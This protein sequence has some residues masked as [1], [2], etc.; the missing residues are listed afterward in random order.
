LEGP[1]Q[2]EFKLPDWITN[3]FKDIFAPAEE[4]EEEEPKEAPAEQIERKPKD[5]LVRS[6]SRGNKSGERL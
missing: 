5:V 4:E 2:E 1:K 6:K 3:P